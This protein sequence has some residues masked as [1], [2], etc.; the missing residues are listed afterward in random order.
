MKSQLLDRLTDSVVFWFLIFALP[1]PMIYS[2]VLATV[3]NLTMKD[4][5]SPLAAPRVLLVPAVN[6]IVSTETTGQFKNRLSLLNQTCEKDDGDSCYALGFAYKGS[7]DV[8]EDAPQARHFMKRACE[9]GLGNACVSVARMFGT[10][11]GGE[12][13]EE[14]ALA[15]LDHGCELK[16]AESCHGIGHRFI[17]SQFDADHL[18]AAYSAFTIACNLGSEEAC[19]DVKLIEKKNTIIDKSK[20]KKNVDHS[21]RM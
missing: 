3:Q 12:Q 18:L 10:G 1:S 13:S 21:R 17:E 19:D 14:F 8:E 16:H 4:N 2:F 15:A 6:Q 11:Y 9:L 7:S 20:E 5:S